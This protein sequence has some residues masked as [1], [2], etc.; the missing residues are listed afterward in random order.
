MIRYLLPR[1]RELERIE[2]GVVWAGVATIDPQRIAEVVNCRAITISP[3]RCSAWWRNAAPASVALPD[4]AV[5]DGHGIQRDSRA[6]AV[7]GRATLVAALG[8]RTNWVDRFLIAPLAR[9][10]LPPLVARG[11][12]AAMLA[13]LVSWRAWRAGGADD[14]LGGIRTRGG[15]RRARL[16]CADRCAGVVARRAAADRAVNWRAPTS[17]GVAT[18][19][20]DIRRGF[21]PAPLPRH[22]SR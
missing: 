14:G 2:P 17:G 13:G 21:T 7:K 16:V 18:L 8:A 6:L 9:L 11:V 3:L 12:P 10:A 1:R 22:Y 19:P 20:L 15:R 4:A 5:R